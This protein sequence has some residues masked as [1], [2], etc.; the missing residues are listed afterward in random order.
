MLLSTLKVLDGL[1]GSVTPVQDK[2]H[3]WLPLPEGDH[4]QSVK[5]AT[6]VHA[7]YARVVVT[8]T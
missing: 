8:L 7:N 3:E 2:R 4:L 6:H 5:T 1:E